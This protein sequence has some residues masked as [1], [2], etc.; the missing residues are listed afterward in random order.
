MN[1][2][3]LE[4]AKEL[5]KRKGRSQCFWKPI[6]LIGTSGYVWIHDPSSQKKFMEGGLGTTPNSIKIIILPNGRVLPFEVEGVDFIFK[7]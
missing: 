1:F 6:G 4:G 2:Y 7:G 5:A 3:T